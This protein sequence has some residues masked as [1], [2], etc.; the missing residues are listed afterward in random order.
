MYIPKY[1]WL[2]SEPQKNCGFCDDLAI[3]S[4]YI[5]TFQLI[6]ENI[7][8]DFFTNGDLSVNPFSLITSN[9]FDF[10]INFDFSG[11]IP[12]DSYFTLY[13]EDKIYIF[14]FTDRVSNF[15]D[16]LYD[17]TV[18]G[19]IYYIDIAM[20]S[21]PFLHIAP[22]ATAGRLQLALSEI[23]D[24]NHG[25]TTTISGL[26]PFTITI[27]GIPA[28]SY[29]YDG[30]SNILDNIN[31]ID[32]PISSTFNLT[33]GYYD[34]TNHR[35]CYFRINGEFSMSI[36]ANFVLDSYYRIYYNNISE[37]SDWIDAKFIIDDGVNPATESNIIYNELNN[38]NYVAALTGVHTLTWQFEDTTP[39]HE[40]GFCF[41]N[42][43]V[44][45]TDYIDYIDVI[46]CNGVAERAELEQT[47][48]LNNV[49]VVLIEPFLNPFQLKIVDSSGNIFYSRYYNIIDQDECINYIKL[50]WT[51]DC[52]FGELDYANLPFTNSLY[53]TGVKIKN[54]LDILDSLDS[55]TADGRQKSIYKNTQ[56]SYELRLHPYLE[57]TQDVLERVFEHKTVN[58]N[59]ELYNAID[60]YQTSELDNGVYTGRVDLLKD[61]TQIISS[62]C[63]C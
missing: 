23:V 1:Q 8:T 18:T 9:D 2:M 56:A 21:T 6:A 14:K 39:E 13:I 19:N 12:Y 5:P 42:L 30:A 17:L 11:E 26:Y 3:P 31:T 38:I 60:I 58:V 51:S 52:L 33:N 54:A 53:L 55:I 25:S 7:G 20:A 63:C 37:F 62:E 28:G 34:S 22:V 49:K 46:D 40:S 43:S 15:P 47:L 48:Y 10:N 61:G 24:V 44:M 35:I 16:P 50:N 4:D 27:A 57:E 32:P 45:E 59:D 36:E 29:L 41:Y